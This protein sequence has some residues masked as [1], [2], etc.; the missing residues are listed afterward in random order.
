MPLQHAYPNYLHE[1][2]VFRAED[3]T[4]HPLEVYRV[5]KMPNLKL[6]P[7][8]ITIQ[9]VQTRIGR[10]LYNIETK[11]FC[12]GLCDDNTL[13]DM[14]ARTITDKGKF[15]NGDLFIVLSVTA[16]AD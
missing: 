16:D 6:T 2:G 7:V 10:L 13:W 14:T 12:F 9:G 5:D 3:S 15:W 4:Y 1:H 11:E 8:N